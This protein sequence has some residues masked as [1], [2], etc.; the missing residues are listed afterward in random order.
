MSQFSFLQKINTIRQPRQTGFTLVELMVTIAVL[1]IIAGIATPTFIEMIRNS[2][3]RSAATELAAMINYARSEAI[4]RSNNVAI[5]KSANP[6]DATPA[7]TTNGDWST[8]WFAFVD[9]N[10][11]GA[12]DTGEP[13][14]RVG[15]PGGGN[16]V[17]SST[18]YANLVR[19]NSRGAPG[20]SGDFQICIDTVGRT[21]DISTI[22]RLHISKGV[23]P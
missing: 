4:K 22:G 23:C 12:V 2:R 1:A 9:A 20:S 18:A 16:V 6:D 5:C 19:F 17:I 8:G 3:A 21:L 7:C 14:L 11:N 13:I 15:R 10:A